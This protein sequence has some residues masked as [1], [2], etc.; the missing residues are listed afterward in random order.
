MFLFSLPRHSPFH[1]L[2]GML[3]LDAFP[4][5][6]PKGYTSPLLKRSAIFPFLEAKLY[7]EFP[8]LPLAFVGC[9][10]FSFFK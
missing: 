8:S 10:L 4:L 1:L 7:G 2:D 6:P 3:T 5:Q 9:Q